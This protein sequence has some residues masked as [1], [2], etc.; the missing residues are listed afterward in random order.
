MSEKILLGSHISLSSPLFYLSTVQ[1]ALEW[2]E[3]AFMFYTGAPQN[4]RRLPTESLK[5]E[6]GNSLLDSVSFPK[7]AIIVHAP[8]IINLANPLK[9]ETRELSKR[10]LL[11]ELKRVAA[12]KLDKLV[13][14]P[15]SSVGESKESG[16]HYIIEGLN[17]VFSNDE[18][19]VKI[20]LETMAGKGS[21]IGSSFEELKAIYEGIEKKDRI[22]ICLDTCHLSDAGYDVSDPKALLEEFSAYLPISLIKA[23]HLNDSLNPPSSHKDRH[24]NIGYGTIGFEKLHKWVVEPALSSVPKILE[25]PVIN[26]GKDTIYPYK[27]E[28]EMLQSGIYEENWKEKLSL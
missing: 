22:G 1:K 7:E 14:H 28:I 4:T 26:N 17:E 12:F 13:L 3:S 18:S 6:E 24:A 15:G 8:Y 19:G 11:D 23:V 9:E 25:T 5:I 2:G 21:E 10:F 16:I 20:L 27:K